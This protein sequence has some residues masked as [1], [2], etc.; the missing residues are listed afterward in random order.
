MAKVVTSQT[1]F[2]SGQ[3]SERV[4]GRT[5]LQAYDQGAKSI[6]NC[7]PFIHGGVTRRPGT[8]FVRE[9]SDSSRPARLIPYTNSDVLSYVLVF[10]DDKIE[11]IRDG[12]LIEVSPGVPFSVAHP[13]S[14]AEIFELTYTQFGRAMFIAHPNHHPKQLT[15]N[16]DTDW[17]FVNPPFNYEALT[18][19][20][21]ENAFVSFKIISGATAFEV[22]DVFTFDTDGDGNI[23]SGP[24]AGG[25]NVGTGDMTGVGA[26]DL[27]DPPGGQTWTVSCS[28]ATE[29]RQQWTVVGSVDGAITSQWV[30]LDYPAACSTFEQRLFFG[31]S[32]SRPQTIWASSILSPFEFSPGP[33]DDDAIQ[34]TIASGTLDQIVHMNSAR[35][36]LIQTTASEFSLSGGNQGLTPSAVIV[37]DQTFHGSNEVTPIRIGREVLFIQRSGDKVRGISFDVTLDANTAPDITILSE[38]ITAS[39]I[40]DATFQQDPDFI[41]WFCTNDGRLLS[42]TL[43]RDQNVIAWAEHI[44]GAT[45]FFESLASIPLAGG[46]DETYCIVS[47]IIDGA[48]VRYIEYIDYVDGAQTDSALYGTSGSPTAIWAGLDHLEGESVDVVLDG[49]VH[50]PVIVDSGT[51]TLEREGTDIEVGLGYDSVLELLHPEISLPDGTSQGRSTSI[52]ELVIRFQDTNACRV[53]GVE[54][55]FR[56]LD[57]D[58]LDSPPAFFTGDKKVTKLGWKPDLNIRITQEV[59]LQWTILAAIIKVVVND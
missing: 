33:D 15:R 56:Q 22:N 55:P 12:E 10:N 52:H 1:S 13:Y 43:E 23:I 28:F 58:V 6:V 5:D 9:V 40:I 39:G 32:P 36:L 16:T 26:S 45:G 7:Y 48:L 24:T 29:R 46:N 21:F 37:R 38:D 34:V 54:V 51:I 4:I 8:S 20:F 31:G 47:R 59:P 50:P 41:A 25:S 35:Q 30:D 2:V 3:I 14:D 19:A 18:D 27:Q 44:T 42:L 17:D 11:F 53:D 57:N 49:A